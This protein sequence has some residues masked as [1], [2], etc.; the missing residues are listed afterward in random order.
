M[1]LLV[2]NDTPLT[3]AGGQILDP[4]ALYYYRSGYVA[5]ETGTATA[6]LVYVLNAYA[7]TSIRLKIY[8]STGSLLAE[9]SASAATGWVNVGISSVSIT[10]GQTYYLAIEKDAYLQIACGAAGYELTNPLHTFGTGPSTITVPGTDD[11]FHGVPTIYADG[12]V[13]SP[14]APTG[15]GLLLGVG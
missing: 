14:S 12:T 10:T 6:L 9:G 4:G 11:Y 3:N 5:S 15:R 2:G 8:D 7:S 13:S 1:T